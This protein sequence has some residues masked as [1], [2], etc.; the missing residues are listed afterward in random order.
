MIALFHE[1]TPRLLDDIRASVVRRDGGDLA[2]S[3]HALIGSLGAFGAK[4]AQSLARQ[5]E[6][7]AHAANYAQTD[8]TFAALARATAEIHQALMLT[9]AG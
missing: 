9:V 7:Q 5:L 1:N 3:A 6:E 4:E 2:R 8:P